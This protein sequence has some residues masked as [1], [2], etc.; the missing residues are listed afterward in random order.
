MRGFASRVL[1]VLAL[2]EV[3]GNRP[4]HATI[5][6]KLDVAQ[7]AARSDVI[8]LGQVEST[9]AR[10]VRRQIVTEALVLVEESIKGAA[11]ARV[12]IIQ[13]GGKV[14]DIRM[15]Q[16]GGAEFRVGDRAIVFLARADGDLRVVGLA[17]GKV[18]VERTPSGDTVRMIPVGKA[19]SESLP[20]ATALA[21]L[22]ALV[23]TR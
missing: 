1:C 17:Q 3:F 10:W 9:R 20:L 7:L 6:A 14:G 21:H 22:R 11:A 23:R 15:R 12:R 8:L 4:T 19:T 2:L 13:M 18:S 5:Y 16:L